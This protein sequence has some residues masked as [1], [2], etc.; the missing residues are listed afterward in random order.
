[1]NIE[2]K[3]HLIGCREQHNQL[4]NIVKANCNNPFFLSFCKEGDKK[5][6]PLHPKLTFRARRIGG[7]DRKILLRSVRVLT[8][9]GVIPDGL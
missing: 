3:D 5:S 7:N 9:T 4:L 8:Y 6:P 1:M 2:I